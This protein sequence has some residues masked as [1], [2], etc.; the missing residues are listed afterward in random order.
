MLVK[1][2]LKHMLSI[3]LLPSNDESMLVRHVGEAFGILFKV[4]F[5]DGLVKHG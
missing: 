1:T 4:Y 5:I 2:L 3:F